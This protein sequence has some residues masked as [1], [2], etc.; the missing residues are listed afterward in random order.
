MAKLN[1]DS[2]YKEL[3]DILSKLQDEN[4]GI[5]KMSDHVKRAKE[6]SEYCK[7]RLRDIEKS[8]DEISE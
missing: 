1:Y 2:A 6:L 5:E 8:L 3:Q 4:I 7:N